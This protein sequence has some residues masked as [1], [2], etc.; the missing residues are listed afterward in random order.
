MNVCKG[1]EVQTGAFEKLEGKPRHSLHSMGPGASCSWGPW[2]D[3]GNGALRNCL[4]CF[5]LCL[6]AGARGLLVTGA[7]GRRKRPLK[8]S[9][10]SQFNS[11]GRASLFFYFLFCSAGLATHLHTRGIIFFLRSAESQTTSSSLTCANTHLLLFPS[12]LCL[13]HVPAL[14]G[15]LTHAGCR[16]LLS[17]R[18]MSSFLSTQ[19][20]GEVAFCAAVGL[21]ESVFKFHF[22]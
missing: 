12:S 14:P 11:L 22:L 6:T 13:T 16:P 17:P 19:R 4:G 21:L 5:T 18:G 7:L 8:C 20:G 15:A 9:K 1:A 3:V 10:S 2:A